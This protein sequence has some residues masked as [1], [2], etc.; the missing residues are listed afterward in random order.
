M[1]SS[2]GEVP[3]EVSDEPR[4]LTEDDFKFLMAYTRCNDQDVLQHR[5][6]NVWREVKRKV[7]IVLVPCVVQC[8]S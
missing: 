2:S 1:A 8:V 7:W 5:V 4:L 3:Y 6:L